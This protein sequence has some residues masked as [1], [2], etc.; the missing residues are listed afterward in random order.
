MD[1]VKSEFITSAVKK[2]QYPE[3]GY[4]EVAFIGRSNVGKSSIINSLTNRRG[5]ARVSNTPGRTRLV[6][7]FLINDRFYLVDLPGYGYAK[8][9]KSEKVNLGQILEEYFNSRAFLKKVVL[10][11][12]S[13]HKPTQDDILMYDFI[14]HYAIPCQVI[15]TKLDKLKRNEIR[16][17]EKIIRDTLDMAPDEQ[18]LMYSSLTRENR[19]AVMDAV[20][21]GL[22]EDKETQA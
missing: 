4:P 10:L 20:F 17:N 7:F 12:D 1:I 13:R 18:I 16:K 22:T 19:E 6:N 21:A 3:G 9:S 11:V 5:L 14:R 8:V 15:A 2:D